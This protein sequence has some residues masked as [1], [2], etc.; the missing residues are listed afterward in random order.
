M[1]WGWSDTD[2]DPSLIH[3]I[4]LKQIGSEEADVI[5]YE[6]FFDDFALSLKSPEYIQISYGGRVLMS[7]YPT[8]C[9]SFDEGFVRMEN[10]RASDI[11]NDEE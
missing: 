3:E 6:N 2:N 8:I 5:F 10:T 7:F 9:F 1:K 11:Q 4:V